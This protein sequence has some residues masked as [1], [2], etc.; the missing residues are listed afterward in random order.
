MT[1]A[2]FA[3][4]VEEVLAPTLQPGEVVLRDNLSAHE[5]ERERVAIEGRGARL[6]YL[7]PYSPDLNP[8]EKCWSKVK[9]APRAAKARPWDALLDALCHALRAVSPEDAAA[10]FAHGGYTVN[11]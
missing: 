9:T 6:E 11:P 4:Y 7:P 10:W 3:T 2:A 1:G 5:G 8:I